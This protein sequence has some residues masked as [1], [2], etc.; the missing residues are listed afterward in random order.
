MHLPRHFINEKPV[1]P[2]APNS[3]FTNQFHLG[4]TSYPMLMSSLREK[5]SESIY[6]R[7]SFG[8]RPP[9]LYM[10]MPATRHRTLLSC[11]T[12]RS[13]RAAVKAKVWPPPLRPRIKGDDITASSMRGS[14]PATMQLKTEDEAEPTV[15]LQLGARQ[16][17]LDATALQEVRGAHVELQ[18]PQVS[19]AIGSTVIS[20]ALSY[21]QSDPRLC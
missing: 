20:A 2:T 6:A 3:K 1:P 15:H 21:L 8:C 18:H 16:L 19:V 4:A 14:R 11:F 5:G 9:C 7:P 10:S 13:C 12:R 17:F